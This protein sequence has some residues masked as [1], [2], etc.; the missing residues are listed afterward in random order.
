M[1]AVQEVD[2]YGFKGVHMGGEG[3]AHLPSRG[4]L[5]GEGV[6]QRPLA[7]GFAGDGNGVIAP[8]EL[9]R[10]ARSRGPLAGRLSHDITVNGGVR[11]ALCR[12]NTA[13]IAP[14]AVA[15][16]VGWPRRLQ[17]WARLPQTGR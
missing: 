9:C 13:T 2:F 14:K 8:A 16:R 15:A 17:S 4:A 7:E 10:H 12:F 3:N 11:A 5:C 6:V 1:A